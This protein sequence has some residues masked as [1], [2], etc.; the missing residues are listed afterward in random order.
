MHITCN[1]VFPVDTTVKTICINTTYMLNFI[2]FEN[3]CHFKSI[4]VQNT[5]SPLSFYIP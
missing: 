4:G 1:S 2:L 5:S 3:I